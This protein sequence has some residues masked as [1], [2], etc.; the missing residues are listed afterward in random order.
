MHITYIKPYFELLTPTLSKL[1]K[2]SRLIMTLTQYI[3]TALLD[4]IMF[5]SCSH[6]SLCPLRHPVY[7]GG[8]VDSLKFFMFIL[9]RSDP[10]VP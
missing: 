9:L 7:Q 1:L 4:P 2:W 8:L 5:M 3:L 10:R 6:I